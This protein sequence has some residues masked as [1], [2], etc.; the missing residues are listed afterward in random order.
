MFR[1]FFILSIL[2]S[3]IALANFYAP[4]TGTSF[5]GLT[6][7]NTIGEW[8]STIRDSDS[9]LI[10][11][12]GSNLLIYSEQFDNA[13]WTK[14]TYADIVANSIK[15]LDGTYTADTLKEYSGSGGGIITSTHSVQVASPITLANSIVYTMSIYV[16]VGVRNWIGVGVN[17]NSSLTS[18]IWSFNLSTGAL[19]SQVSVGGYSNGIFADKKIT[20]LGRGWYRCS[21]SFT[22]LGANVVYPI[23]YI[24]EGDADTQFI[25]IDQSSLYI[26]GAQLAQNDS[27]RQ[28]P[29]VYHQTV[30]NAK[31]LLDLAPT[32][33]PTTGYSYYQDATGNQKQCRVFNGSSQYYSK[34]HDAS[35]NIFD[36]DF[37][38]TFIVKTSTASGTLFQHSGLSTDGFVVD[39]MAGPNVRWTAYKA[40]PA[41]ET[42]NYA[43]ASGYYNLIQL[44]RSSNV[45]AMYV[46]G[47]LASYTPITGGTDGSTTLY[48]GGN[49]SAYTNG[50]ILYTRIDAEALT[51]TQLAKERSQIWGT[52]GAPVSYHT[53]SLFSRASAATTTFSNGSIGYAATNIPRVAGNEGGVLVEGSA[54]QLLTYTGD[55]STNWTKNSSSIAG[56]NVIL[57][58]STTGITNTLHE[59]IAVDGNVQHTISYDYATIIGTSYCNS[60]YIK[61]N[62]LAAIPREWVA[63][64]VRD[65]AKN[66]Y[67][68]FNVRYGYFGTVTKSL[69]VGGVGVQTLLN[70]WYR[71][72]AYGTAENNGTGNAIFYIAGA[73]N[74]NSF[75]GNDQDSVF[76]F[77]PQLETGAFPTSYVPR[78]TDTASSRS[79]DSLT[80]EPWTINKNLF[81]TITP[82]PMFWYNFDQVSYSG[83]TAISQGGNYTITTG[84]NPKLYSDANQSDYLDFN[85]TNDYLTMNSSDFNPSGA[86]S[87]VAA[88]TPGVGVGTGNI[89]SKD[90][91]LGTRGPF[92]LIDTGGQPQ[93]IVW[94]N[95]G[96][97]SSA[98]GGALVAGKTSLVTA[99]YDGAGHTWVKTDL[100]AA[101]TGTGAITT[102]VSTANLVYMGASIGPSQQYLGR[103]NFIGYYNGVVLT[104]SQH[105][106]LY[107]NLKAARSLPVKMGNSYEAKKLT[108][109]FDAKCEYS[110][111][112]DIGIT[113]LLLSISG[114]TGTA[115]IDNNNIRIYAHTDG[116][117][118]ANFNGNDDATYHYA[119]SAAFTNLNTWKH[120][121][122]YL[123]MSNMA[124]NS[125]KIDSVEGT[126]T[127]NSGTENFD[128][129][130]TF[131][132]IGQD[133][134]GTVSGNCSMKNL[135]ITPSY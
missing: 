44:R 15:S 70:G 126:W 93:L 121:R 1:I 72:W 17:D 71:V 99:T 43:L 13:A 79:A 135:R 107:A 65:S 39:F 75:V 117:F 69:S 6:R 74:V 77:G 61:Y 83:S 85:G 110:S 125:Y 104:E 24:L 58:D 46:N 10:D 35:M 49:G 102:P 33:A 50:S 21:I 16:K 98:A 11:R 59:G 20:S 41:S 40:G 106:T 9:Y 7:S 47:T 111:A 129:T 18:Y 32:A 132:R 36:T 108:V 51:D 22:S 130:N 123:D 128:M 94:N 25:G 4:F 76:I 109:E 118:Y 82:S 34:A 100:I 23:V 42:A 115:D 131:I 84:G 8:D 92:Q 27:Y 90:D 112:T 54:T 105:N 26:W 133:Y 28:G 124:N 12:S 95:L 120:H 29:G 97:T 78:I 52:I 14:S 127:G 3:N 66:S 45:L 89:I 57:P 96:T 88:Y 86:F 113:R 2:W 81:A 64:L 122:V 31:T 30:A 56:T 60:V 68:Y 67:G 91:A 103:I 38:A 80:Y 101:G 48:L 73:D 53:K 62:S 114:N 5:S 37:T 119:S 87:I 134:S 19:G 63:I 55:F 116:K